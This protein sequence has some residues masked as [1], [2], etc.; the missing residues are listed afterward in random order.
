MGLP[1][2]E[3]GNSEHTPSIL[4]ERSTYNTTTS[5]K[6]TVT[7]WFRSFILCGQ[8]PPT[9][10]FLH[11][12][13]H[14]EHSSHQNEHSPQSGFQ[15]RLSTIRS[16][17]ISQTSVATFSIKDSIRST[18]GGLIDNDKTE[19]V[20][21]G[22][23]ITPQLYLAMP[24]DNS[25]RLLRICKGALSDPIEVAL[26]FARLD[27]S[28]PE[29]EALSYVWGSSIRVSHIIHQTTQEPIPV[30]ENLYDALKGLRQTG[31]DRLIWVDALC[32]NQ[33]DGNE[34]GAQVRKMNFVYTKATRVIVWLGPDEDDQANGAFG[35]LCSLA[36]VEGDHPHYET[37]SQDYAPHVPEPCVEIKKEDFE[38]W[39]KVM[40]FFCST[41]FTRLWVLQEIALAEDAIFV[42]GDCSI[43]WTYVGSA[44]KSIRKNESMS[45]LLHTRNL[46][47]AFLMWHLST[48]CRNAGRDEPKN[49]D[50][51]LLKP[52]SGLISF[53]HLLDIIRSF[54][55][56]DPRDKIY[57][58]LGFPTML[59][60]R[61]ADSIVP[62]YS[63]STGRIYTDVTCSYLVREKNLDILAWV[64]YDS[65]LP[66]AK[67]H[68]DDLPTWVPNFNSAA[69]VFT[70]SNTNNGHQYSAGFS[71]PVS[72]GTCTGSHLLHLEGA[73]LDTISKIGH[74]VTYVP[75]ENVDQHLKPLMQWYLDAGTSLRELTKI[76]TGGRTKRGLLSSPLQKEE[77]EAC[78][79]KAVEDYGLDTSTL[80]TESSKS[81]P[82][83]DSTWKG[84]IW[85]VI[86]YRQPFVTKSGRI[87]LGPQGL[88]EGD[89]VAVLWGGQCPFV[90]SEADSQQRMLKGQCYVED[91]MD[92]DA[93]A[94]F[95]REKGKET[96][97]FEFV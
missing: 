23:L 35:M 49:G 17:D 42:W 18:P 44:I 93:V 22:S 39:R 72:L 13:S 75:I 87:G 56:T 66:R 83:G 90:I 24:Y 9:W 81:S 70:L 62:D 5:T 94:E 59:D 69:T 68:I 57:G 47:N 80:S 71:R 25:I 11:R 16:L 77:C 6:R 64:L 4:D 54:E 45:S 12:R 95:V 51:N 30:T 15:V 40:A 79:S 84:T 14:F 3:K 8:S 88:K 28:I 92:G 91:W 41:W 37:R 38:L 10:R 76:L 96:V 21:E 50:N 31:Q 48:I 43:S 58:L 29:Y 55:A 27:D 85:R 53:L 97:M 78:L 61:N 63:F 20:L 65:S 19:D 52:R 2:I 89:A 86:T 60:D 36:D 32:I 34:K 1:E 46:H 67:E 33:A 7:A 73:V 82:K 26:E 74:S